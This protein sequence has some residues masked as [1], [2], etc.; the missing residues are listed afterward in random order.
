MADQTTS[1]DH[2]GNPH[3][4]KALAFVVGALILAVGLL[5]YVVFGSGI[6]I[7][8]ETVDPAIDLSDT[9]PSVSAALDEP[10]DDAAVADGAAA[11]GSTNN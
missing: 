9:T 5:A 10:A 7:A 11:V 8:G 3:S 2:T 6:R 4:A 1:R